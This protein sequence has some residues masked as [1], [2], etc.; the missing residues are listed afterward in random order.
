MPFPSQ[1]GPSEK[2]NKLGYGIK[3]NEKKPPTAFF[4]NNKH[5]GVPEAKKY[6][7]GQE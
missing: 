4:D 7:N 3:T 5:T 6:L 2:Q 1:G